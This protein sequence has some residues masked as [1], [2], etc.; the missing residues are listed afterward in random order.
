MDEE[1]DPILQKLFA[2]SQHEL[3]GEAFTASVMTRS[4]FLRYQRLLPWLGGALALTVTLLLLVPLQEFGVLIAL[5]VT[6]ILTITLFDLGEGWLAL[7]FSPVNN[8]ASLIVLGVKALRMGR[9][10]II[11]GSY[12]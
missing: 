12:A 8:I 5:F 9:K 10:K 2:E 4:R 1:R 6:D 11:G 7:V 3:D